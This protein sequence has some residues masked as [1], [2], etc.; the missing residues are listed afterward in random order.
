MARRSPVARALLA[1]VAVVII[2][3]IG[4]GLWLVLGPGPMDFARGTRVPLSES[5][6]PGPSGVP[7]E[8][9]NASLIERGQYLTRAADCGACATQEIVPSSNS[10][11]IL[12]GRLILLMILS[13]GTHTHASGTQKKRLRNSSEPLWFSR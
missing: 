5:P 3:G 2:A 13:C 10:V 9:A 4:F 1:I 11:V 8:L 12:S 6:G 7:T